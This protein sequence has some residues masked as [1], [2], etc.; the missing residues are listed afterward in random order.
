MPG[1]GQN[2][3]SVFSRHLSIEKRVNVSNRENLLS[4]ALAPLVTRRSARKI[5]GKLVR[6]C[7]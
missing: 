4:F 3:A 2:E 7:K 6:R 1:Y 5:F